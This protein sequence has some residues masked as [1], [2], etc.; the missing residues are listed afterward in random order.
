MFILGFEKNNASAL[1]SLLEI[2]LIECKLHTFRCMA[3]Q[4]RAL[5][6]SL[7]FLSSI[8]QADGT[9]HMNVFLGQNA[10][11]GEVLM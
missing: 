1:L 8:N 9:K 2:H 11:L 7:V 10:H 3:A 6:S 5:L 4:S